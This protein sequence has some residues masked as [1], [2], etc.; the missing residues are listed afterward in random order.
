MKRVYVPVLLLMF[1]LTCS[2]RGYDPNRPKVVMQTSFGDIALELYADQA[3][4]TVENF[5]MYVNSGFYDGLLFHRIIADYIIQGGGYYYSNGMPYPQ[6]TQ[7]PIVNESYNG[8]SNVRGTIA[9]ARYSSPDS[10][11]S[12]FYINVLDNGEWLDRSQAWDGVGYCVFGR[13]ISGMDVVD[14]IART[15]TANIG[16]GFDYFPYPEIVYT[17]KVFVPEPQYWISGD[18]NNDGIVNFT[19]FAILT[20]SFVSIPYDPTGDTT[21]NQDEISETN[22]QAII[23]FTQNWLSTTDWH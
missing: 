14:A 18:F 22:L 10:A 12:Q 1:C 21:E 8:L 9:M 20:S 17:E 2:V 13:V 7:A 4:I 5:L 11:T 19:D 6:P 23:T 16:A 15:P 3:P